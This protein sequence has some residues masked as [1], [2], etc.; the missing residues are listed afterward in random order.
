MPRLTW[1]YSKKKR[2]LINE[3]KNRAEALIAMIREQ[4]ENCYKLNK[5]FM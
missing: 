3:I 1:P 4:E 2:M 5:D